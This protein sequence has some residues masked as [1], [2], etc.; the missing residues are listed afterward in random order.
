MKYTYVLSLMAL[1]LLS[2]VA[3]I[4]HSGSVFANAQVNTAQ[5]GYDIKARSHHATELSDHVGPSL[6]EFLE[7]LGSVL[8]D[9]FEDIEDWS[10]YHAPEILPNGDILIRRKNSDS[11]TNPESNDHTGS[12]TVDL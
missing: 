12:E 11:P 10:V 8:G 5:K 2:S 4:E 6:R 1:F 3:L 7:E 9:I